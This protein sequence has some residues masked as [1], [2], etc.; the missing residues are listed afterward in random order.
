MTILEIIGSIVAVGN[1]IAWLL[2]GGK[3]KRAAA[4]AKTANQQAHLAR[5][6]A[7]ALTGEVAVAISR[8]PKTRGKKPKRDS[9]DDPI[10]AVLP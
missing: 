10:R 8:L 5:V 9:G 7:A 4:E 3:I 1:L 6:T 2:A